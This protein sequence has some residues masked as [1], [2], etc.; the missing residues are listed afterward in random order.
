MSY[1]PGCGSQIPSDSRFCPG[2]G[3]A[4]GTNETPSVSSPKPGGRALGSRGVAFLVAVVVVALVVGLVVW[5]SQPSA[6]HQRVQ[7][8]AGAAQAL[9]DHDMTAVLK[10]APNGVAGTADTSKLSD[11]LGSMSAS[12]DNKQ[13]SGDTLTVRGTF[14]NSGN[15]Y[16]GTLILSPAS[17]DAVRMAV[18]DGQGNSQTFFCRLSHESSGWKITGVNT[19]GSDGTLPTSNWQDPWQYLAN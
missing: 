10:Y 3:T 17:S 16:K 11:Q 12:V 6:D 13:W 9:A 4:A 18:A 15:D 7:A 14:T 5:R 1:C 8:V 19:T 2:C